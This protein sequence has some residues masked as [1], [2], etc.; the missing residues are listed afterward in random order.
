MGELLGS[1]ARKIV[2]MRCKPICIGFSVLGEAIAY[3]YQPEI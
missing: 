1:L 2:E 3:T